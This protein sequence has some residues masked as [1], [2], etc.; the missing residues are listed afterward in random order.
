MMIRKLGRHSSGRSTLLVP[1]H[2][3][4]ENQ[5][6]KIAHIR[7]TEVLLLFIHFSH[8]TIY[9]G[10]FSMYVLTSGVPTGNSNPQPELVIFF[11]MVIK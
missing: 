6:E 1:T 9:L 3:K 5:K 10:T 4:K 11:H 2:I 7:L 8:L